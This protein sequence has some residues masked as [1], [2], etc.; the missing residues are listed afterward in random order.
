MCPTVY[1]V[2]CVVYS[3]D[4]VEAYCYR[5]YE[6]VPNSLA[7]TFSSRRMVTVGRFNHKGLHQLQKQSDHCTLYSRSYFDSVFL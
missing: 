1:S 2:V 5:A 3:A 4:V 6:G 7:S